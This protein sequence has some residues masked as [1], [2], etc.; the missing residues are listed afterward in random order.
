MSALNSGNA[1]GGAASARVSGIVADPVEIVFR[2]GTSIEGRKAGSTH[3][4]DGALAHHYCDV[5]GVA[6]RAARDPEPPPK[7]PQDR[8]MEAPPRG[9]R[10]RED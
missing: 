8:A 3:V 9:R 2:E 1:G 4:V 7:G 5:L 6:D 10:G